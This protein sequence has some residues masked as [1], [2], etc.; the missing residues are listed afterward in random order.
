MASSWAKGEL[1][2]SNSLSSHGLYCM[3]MKQ[4][5]ASSKVQL[6]TYLAFLNTGMKRIDKMGERIKCG[7]IIKPPIVHTVSNIAALRCT[8]LS[9]PKCAE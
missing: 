5:V 2:M 6:A 3:Y 1:G 7:A 9:T 4:A 8:G